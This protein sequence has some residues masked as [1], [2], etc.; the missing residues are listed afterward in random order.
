MA[1][2]KA[3]EGTPYAGKTHLRFG[4]GNISS[5]ATPRRGSLPCKNRMIFAAGL[6]LAVQVAFGASGHAAASRA[7]ASP[8]DFQDMCPPG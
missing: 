2:G 5:A 8:S 3:L 6:G 1:A 7:S 4:E